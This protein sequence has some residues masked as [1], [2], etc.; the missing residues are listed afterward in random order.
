MVK[1]LISGD[2]SPSNRIAEAIEREDYDSFF[3]QIKELNKIADYSIVNFESTVADDTDIPIYKYGPNLKCTPKALAALKWAGFNMVTLANNHF[4]DYGQSS[5]KKSFAAIEQNNI[6]SVGA[7]IN[8]ESAVRT[9]YKEINGKHFAFINCCEHEFSIATDGH[10]GCNPLNPIQ[11]YYDIT[12]AKKQ[13]DFVIVIVHGGHEH[14]QLPSPRMKETYRFF[15]D[16][17][18]DAVINHHQHCFSGFEYYKDKPIAY[19]LGNLCFDYGVGKNK[20]W[21]EGCIAELLFDGNNVSIKLLPY[22][23]CAEIPDIKF[24]EDRTNFESEISNLNSIIADDSQLQ[25]TVYNYYNDSS[26]HYLSTFEPYAPIR[27]LSSAWSRGLLPDTFRG[28]RI[29]QAENM[30]MCESHL[31]RLRFAVNKKFNLIK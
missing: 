17:G 20:T 14:F 15:I 19:G 26:K 28:K 11:Q 10:G 12:E 1:I 27:L 5:L 16:A 21:N 6:D 7:G 4:F 22:I 23:Q 3:S 31:D 24:L 25:L 13:A 2:F 9:F 8:Q 29:S 30:L 18:A